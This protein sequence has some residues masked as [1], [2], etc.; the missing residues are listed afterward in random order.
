MDLAKSEQIARCL[1]F[2]QHEGYD[3]KALWHEHTRRLD[4]I[5]SPTGDDLM[6]EFP[7]EYVPISDHFTKGDP[8]VLQCSNICV[9]RSYLLSPGQRQWIRENFDMTPTRTV[10]IRTAEAWQGTR[11]PRL[12]KF[13]SDMHVD[14]CHR[15]K[16]L[17]DFTITRPGQFFRESQVIDQRLREQESRPGTI[18]AI[19]D[20]NYCLVN[21]NGLETEARYTGLALSVGVEV[22]LKW[23]DDQWQV[24]RKLT[25]SSA[26]ATVRKQRATRTFDEMFAELESTLAQVKFNG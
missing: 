10:T 6:F 17:R 9:G 14:P 20:N 11:H 22:L 16:I 7:L 5:G 15:S 18:T 25:R 26:D 12:L 3:V 8:E 2:L 4:N 1:T 24:S 13:T 23:D 19:T 21:C